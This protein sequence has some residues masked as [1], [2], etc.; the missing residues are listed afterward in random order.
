MIL[1]FWSL[2]LIDEAVLLFGCIYREDNF[3]ITGKCRLIKLKG[4]HWISLRIRGAH[5]EEGV[6]NDSLMANRDVEF[7]FVLHYLCEIGDL[8][9]LS[10][11]QVSA[12]ERLRR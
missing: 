5:E 4:S 9:D 12:L 2:D 1:K 6:A 11:D 8:P 3:V 10:Q 7:R